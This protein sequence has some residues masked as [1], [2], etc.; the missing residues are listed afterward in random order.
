VVTLNIK[1]QTKSGKTLKMYIS[2]VMSNICPQIFQKSKRLFY[3]SL[4]AQ[5]GER[6]SVNSQVTG[7][8]PV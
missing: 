7:S 1:I 2:L 3:E 6:R 8:K 5:S 4:V